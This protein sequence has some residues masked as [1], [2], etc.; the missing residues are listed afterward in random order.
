MK[1]GDVPE[2]QLC[3]GNGVIQWVHSQLGSSA[4]ATDAT[5]VGWMRSGE[6]IAGAS[7][8][9]WNGANIYMH[10]AAKRFVPTFVAAIMDYP[11]RQLECRRVTGMITE[12]NVQSRRFAEHLGARIEG[13]MQDAAINDNIV[14]YGLLRKD[15]LRWL[16]P[17]YRRRIGD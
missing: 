15:A 6:I 12:K 4:P 13:V 10:I 11:F 2:Q 1:H 5:G 9:N 17:A 8:N 3:I 16:T 14:V 7:F